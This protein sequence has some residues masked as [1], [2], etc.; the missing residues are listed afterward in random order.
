MELQLIVRLQKLFIG[1]KNGDRI[2]ATD[3]FLITDDF[4]SLIR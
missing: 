3:G 2:L 1:L 4:Y